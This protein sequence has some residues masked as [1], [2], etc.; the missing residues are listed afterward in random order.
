MS[1]KF[2]FKSFPVKKKNLSFCRSVRGPITAAEF[3]LV[4]FGP[5][6][7]DSKGFPYLELLLTIAL[8]GDSGSMSGILFQLFAKPSRIPEFRRPVCR[9]QQHTPGPQTKGN[10]KSGETLPEAQR[11]HEW[12]DHHDSNHGVN[13]ANKGLGSSK[14][15]FLQILMIG[16]HVH[17]GPL[18]RTRFKSLVRLYLY[19]G[20]FVSAF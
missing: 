16:V 4:F 19:C 11:G 18:K 14:A 9:L 13:K 5:G 2:K 8:I 1:D 17:M 15:K 12:V 3:Q 7:E 10:K 20:L 6:N